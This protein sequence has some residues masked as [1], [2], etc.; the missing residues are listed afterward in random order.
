MS[1]SESDQNTVANIVRSTFE[2]VFAGDFSVFD[3][4]PG[5]GALREHFPPLLVAFPDFRAELK[6]TLVDGD[7]V[8]LHW[9]FRG[10][11]RG[12]LFGMQ[13]TGVP[14]Q[15]Q[16]VGISRVENGRIVQYN[17]EVGWL[18]VFRQIGALERLTGT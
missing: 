17:S 8:A 1:T 10:T 5:L 9:V 7:R 6:Q 3:K 4:H 14:V 12:V 11:H 2:S 16:N 15:F 13:P 18:S